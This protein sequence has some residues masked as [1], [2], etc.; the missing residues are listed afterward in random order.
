VASTSSNL[1]A[2][3]VSRVPEQ[4]EYA[5]RAVVRAASLLELLRASDG[6]AALNELASRSGLA[7]ASVFRMLR[8]LEGLG[9]VE[10]N[11]R[12]DRYRLGVRCL[13]LGQAYLEQADLRRE[14]LP[15]LERLRDEFDETVHLA[16]LDDLRVVYLEKL[17][18]TKAVGIMMSRVG[19]T[20]PS[21]C[22]GLGKAL[23]AHA[24]G[25]PALAL[26]ERGELRRYTS[27]TICEPAAL[28]AELQRIREAGYA[29]DLEEHEPG[30]RCVATTIA[31]RRGEILAA[32]SIAGPAQRLS[33]RA[34]RGRLAVAVRAAARE[35]GSRMGA[36]ATELSA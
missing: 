32:V 34:L 5:I 36:S 19:R 2:V 3:A 24:D 4:P 31:G 14:A 18:T 1:G 26:A 33:E 6:G 7:K 20:A 21:Y 9:L 11:L 22:T 35:I 13:E 23:L 30:V 28:R 15:V 29:L 8:T 12:G 25:D 10:R 16:V 17:E 27:N